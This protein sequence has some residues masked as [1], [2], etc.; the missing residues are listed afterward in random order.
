M[1]ILKLLRQRLEDR[2]YTS[3]EVVKTMRVSQ[4]SKSPRLLL[5]T[6][7]DEINRTKI[8]RSAYKLKDSVKWPKVYISADLT[9]REREVNQTFYNELRFCK[10][11]G[12]KNLYIKNGHIVTRQPRPSISKPVAMED[13]TES[14][15]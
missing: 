8:L 13:S 15:S 3:I 14:S 6:L 2:L 12:E 7:N 5:V 1:K 10:S 11:K 4:Q 9:P